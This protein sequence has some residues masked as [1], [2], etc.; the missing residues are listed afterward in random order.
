MAVELARNLLHKLMERRRAAIPS[1]LQRRYIAPWFRW[2]SELYSLGAVLRALTGY[3]TWLPLMVNSDHGVDRSSKVWPNECEVTSV[4]YLTWFQGKCAVLKSSHS[5]N[6]IWIQHPWVT[7]RR[8]Y[9]IEATPA[10]TLLFFFPHSNEGASPVFDVMRTLQLPIDCAAVN[11]YELVVILHP[12]DH[13]G[14]LVRMLTG[15]GLNV[16]T[17]GN[18]SSPHFVQNFYQQVRSASLVMAVN[19]T[20]AVFFAHELGVPIWLPE[21]VP[22]EAN[23]RGALGAGL[24]SQGDRVIEPSEIDDWKRFEEVSSVFPGNRTE[25]EIRWLSSYVENVLGCDSNTSAE[26]LAEIFARSF[27]Q[28]LSAIPKLYI[29]T[30]PKLVRYVARTMVSRL[31]YRRT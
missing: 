10:G 18:S 2:E 15:M 4:P 21:N 19:P 25:D 30:L 6:G 28:N 11:G 3:P 13:K 22:Y 7:W 1:V 29:S 24:I 9:R 26:E 27:L 14:P 23:G 17:L 31:G 16:T 5:I 12:H 8:A 20:S